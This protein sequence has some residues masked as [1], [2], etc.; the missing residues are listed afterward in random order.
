[1]GGLSEDSPPSAP[2]TPQAAKRD[3]EVT[4]KMPGSTYETANSN[5]IW[6]VFSQEEIDSDFPLIVASGNGAAITD[7]DGHKYLDLTSGISRAS[8]LGYSH[9]GMVAAV[10]EQLRRLHHAGS[11]PL[12]ADTVIR[13]AA[14]LAELAPGDLECSSFMVS[15]SEANET[16]IKIAKLYQRE[17]GKPRAYKVISRW[18]SYHGSVGGGQQASDWLGVRLPFEP[19][20]PG[21]TRIPG[22]ARNSCPFGGEEHTCDL[23][24]ADYLAYHVEHEGP[25]L[26]AAVV[27]EPIGQANGV[28]IPPRGYLE[29]VREICDEYGIILIADEVITGFGRTGRWFGVEHWNVVPDI[30]TVGKAITAGYVPLSAVIVRR[31]VRRVLASLPD[32]H[33]YGGHAG[34]AAAALA[35]IEIYEKDGLVNRAAEMGGQL[36]SAL[37]PLTELTSVADVR[38][39]GLWASIEFAVGDSGSQIKSSLLRDIVMRTREQGVLVSQNGRSIE[40]APP[41]IVSEDELQDGVARF[42]SAVYE[43]CA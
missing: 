11:G 10:C 17:S 38:G 34:G 14:R 26:V 22:P 27:L 13:L 7:V 33:T 20:I 23:R 24:C 32:V 8:A 42:V 16:A 5:Y 37:K 18:N 2:A 9:E 35:A 19:G 6:S 28:Q 1:M 25:E 3:S 39:L 4:R 29:R 41:F 15:G 21:F 30:M 43:M 40:L 31:Q 36:L 12:Q